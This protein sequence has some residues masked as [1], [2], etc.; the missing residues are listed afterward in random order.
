MSDLGEKAL[1]PTGLLDVLP[2][3]A[4]HEAEIVA[5][6]LAVFAAEGYERVKPPMI[7]F[8]ETLLTGAGAALAPQTFRLMDPVS[9]RMMGLRADMTTQ[10]ARIAETRLAR[11]PRPLRLCYAGQVLR[12]KGTQLRSERQFGEAGAELIG[13]E[14]AAADA[15]VALL[16]AGALKALGVERLS[17]D[18]SLPPLVGTVC[19][20]LGFDDAATEQL[21]QLLDRKDAAGVQKLAGARAGRLLALLAAAGP[22]AKVLA[23]LAALELPPEASSAVQRL[24]SVVE[25]VIASDPELVLTVDPVEHRGFEYQTGVS[26]TLFAQGV[27]GELGRGGRYQ[28]IRPDGGGE[29]ATGFTLYLDSILRALPEPVSPP[30]LFLPYDIEPAVARALRAEGWITLAALEPVTDL[31][32]EARRLGCTHVYRDRAVVALEG[33]A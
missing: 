4:A 23:A 32:A 16:A 25:R 15:E 2:P 30:R 17:L 9:Q 3:E 13:S 20:E 5:R 28:A 18:L 27:R 12:V 21:R 6:L 29:P 11:A 19:R 33:E 26:F 7:E 10:V 14:S 8:E 24:T 1:L 22:A 31:I